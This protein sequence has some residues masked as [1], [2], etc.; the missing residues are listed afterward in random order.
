[1]KAL[2][3][4]LIAR[5]L[6]GEELQRHRLSQRQVGSAIDL[7]HTA[8]PQK[9]DDAVASAEQRPGDEAAFVFSR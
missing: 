1:M 7:A 5:R 3:Q 8:A 6:F 4:A 9:A 2:K